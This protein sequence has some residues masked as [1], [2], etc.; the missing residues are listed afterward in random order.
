MTLPFSQKYSGVPCI[1]AVL[2][3]LRAASRS[4]R[5]TPSEKVSG[6]FF[7]GGDFFFTAIV[8]STSV[9]CPN[10][11]ITSTHPPA[12]GI[13]ARNS[14]SRARS[15]AT[16]LPA[17]RCALPNA[18]CAER[19]RRS[20]DFDAMT[21]CLP[22]AQLPR[23]GESTQRRFK[24][25]IGTRRSEIVYASQEETPRSQRRNL[26]SRGDKP[27]G[28]QVSVNKLDHARDLGKIF[29]SKRR[30]PRPVWAGNHDAP[31]LMVG[32]HEGVAASA[33]RS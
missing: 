17:A 21:S 18:S 12:V 8:R 5:P 1:R 31:R 11:R 10:C 9:F 20:D 7:R 33:R 24:S 2:R 19:S 32:S 26:C 28:N 29:A 15:D 14:P 6:F 27:R 30:L 4:P 3:A 13:R 22:V 23:V 16:L 25:K